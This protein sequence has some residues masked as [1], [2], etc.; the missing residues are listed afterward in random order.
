MLGLGGRLESR[1]ANGSAL[2]RGGHAG[3]NI[4]AGL[5][6]VGA[7][8]DD[9]GQREFNPYRQSLHIGDALD[10]VDDDRFL[11]RELADLN[12]LSERGLDDDVV[13]ELLDDAD[14][15]IELFLGGDGAADDGLVFIEGDDQVAVAL[16]RE[17]VLDFEDVR[18]AIFKGGDEVAVELPLAGYGQRGLSRG[19]RFHQKDLAVGVGIAG[20]GLNDA[21]DALLG[22]AGIVDCV[23]E[24]EAFR[25]IQVDVEPL[26]S[27]ADGHVV[28]EGA[29]IA[30]DREHGAAAGHSDN[31]KI[32]GGGC[33]LVDFDD[34][35]RR[36]A[37]AFD[38]AVDGQEFGFAKEDV[39]LL[40]DGGLGAAQPA[41]KREQAPEN[42]QITDWVVWE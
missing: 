33:D 35:V 17:V 42:G 32:V 38:G 7:G 2:G 5:R 9:R 31:R 19:K 1:T 11:L 30:L 37:E 20:I 10:V 6:G 13:G 29:S 21:D 3:R 14:G 34:A 15:V 8:G 18:A 23:G 27:R 24:G 25:F 39:E 16:G 36:D 12:L 28:E 22:E 4:I 40:R 26:G 41:A